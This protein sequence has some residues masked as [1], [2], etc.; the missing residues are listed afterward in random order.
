[1]HYLISDD[2]RALTVFA[3]L[4]ERAA[5]RA[6]GDEIGQDRHLWDALE[7]LV[8]NS[9]LQWVAPD[10]CGDL[11][12]A[13]ILGLWGDCEALPNGWTLGNGYK[14]AGRWDDT[15]WGHRIT[16]RWAFVEYETRS[17][18]EDLRDTGR[19]VFVAP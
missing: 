15:I 5:L 2:R 12:A 13:P 16:E 19:A 10:L 7:P 9:E 11:T 4:S 14:L 8:C 18:L 17:P 1:M 3:D 6:L